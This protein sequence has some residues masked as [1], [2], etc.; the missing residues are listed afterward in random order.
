MSNTLNTPVEALELE[1]PLRVDRVRGAARLG[2]RRARTAAATASSA[3]SR[4]WRTMTYSLLTERRRHAPP[5]RTAAASP[6]RAGATCSTARSSRR[7]RRGSWARGSDCGSRRPEA[8]AR[9]LSRV[10]FIGLGIMGSRMAANLGAGRASR[11]TVW[12]RTRGDGRG[13]G[14]GARRRAWPTRPAAAPRRADVVITMVVDG[15][16]VEHDPARRRT[17]RPSGARPRARCSSTARRSRP[18]RPGR[19]APRW[20]SAGIGF[21][22]APV[23]GSS[24]KAEDGTLT[25][26]AGG[27]RATSSAPGRCSRRWAKLVVHVGAA[28]ARPERE[29]DQQRGRRRQRGHAG[30]G[31]RGRP[32][33]TGVDLDALVEVSAPAPAAR[34]WSTSR[35]ARC[36][37]TTTRRCSSSS[38]CSRTCGSASSEAAGRGRRR[39]RPPRRPATCS[40][41]R[42]PRPRRRGLRGRRR[43]RSRAWPDSGLER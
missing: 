16:Q 35:P 32:T 31:A 22:D 11:S 38:T 30:P 23:T 5:A 8:A 34:R 12:N 10:G 20:P 21:V 41:R 28:R 7:R 26:M 39:S 42:W 1:F 33:P 14:R 24:P 37:P 43:G 19:S 27:E 3:R 40:R 29:A 17:A 6:A 18:P 13:V 36:A 9:W 2:R 4:R 25:I 15:A